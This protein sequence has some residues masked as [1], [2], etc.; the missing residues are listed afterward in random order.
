MSLPAWAPKLF[1]CQTSPLSRCPH[2]ENG[3]R[4]SYVLVAVGLCWRHV[5]EGCW[6]WRPQ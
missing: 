3:G 4:N 6:G 5:S 1:P 2:L